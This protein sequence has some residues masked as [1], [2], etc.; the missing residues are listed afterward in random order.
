MIPNNISYLIKINCHRLSAG[1]SFSKIEFCTEN[2][3]FIRG[4][5]KKVRGVKATFYKEKDIHMSAILRREGRNRWKICSIFILLS[6]HI[7]IITSLNY[8]ILEIILKSLIF[9]VSFR[10][11]IWTMFWPFTYLFSICYVFLP[12]KIYKIDWCHWR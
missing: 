2:Q 1:V 6:P 12:E 10:M 5:Y 3:S 11:L 4:W 9:L 7:S 8:R